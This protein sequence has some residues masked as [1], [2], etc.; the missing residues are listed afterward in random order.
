M[1]LPPAQARRLAVTLFRVGLR[2]L[3]RGQVVAG[4]FRG[5][6]YLHQSHGSVYN[7]KILGTYEAELSDLLAR[8]P[9]AGFR[10]CLD[11]GAAE[12]FYAV[13]LAR[14]LGCPVTAFELD[15]A[16][17]PLITALAEANDLGRLLTVRGGC[18]LPALQ[19]E[20]A[21]EDHPTLVVCDIEG[22]E[23][24]LLDPE[25]V[26][27]L[28]QAHLL[29]EVHDCFV[30]GT[31]ET[32]RQRFEPSHQIERRE[33]QPRTTHDFPAVR[34]AAA[35]PARWRMRLMTEGRGPGMYWYWMVPRPAGRTL[36]PPSAS[37]NAGPAGH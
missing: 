10:R 34:W 37:G 3:C 22:Y 28:R 18:D 4:P 32:L 11:I 30:P 15:P 29:V 9:Q 27:A 19:R 8:L 20:L 26:P 1:S 12:G 6:R 2:G 25:Q 33:C 14:L 5:L 7:A 31:G 36:P 21:G 24:I 17:H 23:K 13:G 35:V 16:A